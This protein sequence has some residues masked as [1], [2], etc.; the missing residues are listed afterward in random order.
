MAPVFST[1]VK[2]QGNIKINWVPTYV[3]YLAPKVTETNAAGSLDLSCY[4]TGWAPSISQNKGTA[5][6][7]LCTTIE[8]EQFGL[9]SLTIADLMY[10]VTP[11]GAALSNGM[12][13]YEKL[14][15]GT[16]GYFQERLGLNA[17]TSD[18]A[19]GQ[20]VSVWPVT[21]GDRLIMGDP[22][23]EFAEFMVTQA[24]IVTGPRVERVA[25]VA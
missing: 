20:F 14:I 18:W 10:H 1:G 6:N 12:L 8:Y 2:S 22:T 16:S 7:R 19:I 13:A 15:P 25:L 9:T 3:S 5:P 21:L 23:D 11:Q 4:L 17:I 24:V